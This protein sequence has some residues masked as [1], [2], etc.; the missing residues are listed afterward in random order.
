MVSS[1]AKL[2]LEGGP[3]TVTVPPGDR[4]E[5][6]SEAEINAVAETLRGGKVYAPTDQF[7]RE[8]AAFVG[9]R[10]ALALCNGTAALHS[11]LFACGVRA[12]DEVIVPSYTWH[13]SIT[14]IL[15]CGG[16]PVFCEVDPRTWT[17]DPEDIRRRISDRTRAVVVTHVLGNP[18]DMDAILAVTRPRGIKVVEDA[19]HAHGATWRG[20]QVGAL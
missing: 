18:A 20:R 8:F 1:A 2:A 4:W 15:H 19:S 13:A 7:E 14:P 17:A 6:I 11:A 16:T 9:T 12:G 5:S 3:R 10:H